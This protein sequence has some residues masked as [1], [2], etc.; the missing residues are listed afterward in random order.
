ML[1]EPT[2]KTKT[3]KRHSVAQFC[4]NV[5]TDN[6]GAEHG[7]CVCLRNTHTHTEKEEC[8]RA[9]EREREAPRLWTDE[10]KCFATNFAFCGFSALAAAPL[11]SH[12]LES[13]LPQVWDF[14]FQ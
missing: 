9:S 4:D 3:Q 10:V 8:E 1:E 14:Y 11:D 6:L 5:N 12:W 2:E 13:C 7:V